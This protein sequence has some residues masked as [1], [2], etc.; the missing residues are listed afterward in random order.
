MAGIGIE[1]VTKRFG[2]VT[3]VRVVR[4]GADGGVVAVGGE[5]PIERPRAAGRSRGPDGAGRDAPK[6]FG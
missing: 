1:H 5:H 4:A 3:A 6:T 2:G